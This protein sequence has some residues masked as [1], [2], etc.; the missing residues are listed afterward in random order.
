MAANW[1]KRYS[2]RLT[3][4]DTAIHEFLEQLPSNKRSEAIRYLLEVAVNYL[5]AEDHRQHELQQIMQA[6]NDIK[7]VQT[8]QYDLLRQGV[9]EGLAYPT[10]RQEAKRTNGE[11]SNQAVADTANAF[12]ASFGISDE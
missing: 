7:A 9:Q 1:K 2:F 10:E 8:D 12:L 6:L 5:K 11:M 4:H 3:D